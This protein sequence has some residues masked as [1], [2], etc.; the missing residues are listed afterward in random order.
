MA[1]GVRNTTPT[2]AVAACGRPSIAR[3]LCTLHYQRAV[4]GRDLTL[5]PRAAHGETAGGCTSAEYRAWQ[6]MRA[7]CSD[8]TRKDYAY[9]GGRGVRVCAV[10]KASFEAF[11]RDVGRRPTA[12][13]T[14]DRVNPDGDYRPG[15]VRWVTRAEQSR[16]RRP[17]SMAGKSPLIR[18]ISA[19]DVID[20]IAGWARRSG[21]SPS[22]IRR[23]LRMGWDPARAVTAAKRSS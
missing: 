7:R 11:L 3:T 23:R 9:Y 19:A 17:F 6:N 12:A 16:N 20:S 4:E 13:H 1:R 22:C 18:W 10:W 21:L 2:C 14:L 5:P 15:N 8:P